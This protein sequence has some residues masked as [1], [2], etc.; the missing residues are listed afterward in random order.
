MGEHIWVMPLLKLF[1]KEGFHDF[2]NIFEA[3][4]KYGSSS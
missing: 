4:A 1:F 2:Y 3:R